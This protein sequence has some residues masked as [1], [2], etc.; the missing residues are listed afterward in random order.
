MKHDARV[1]RRYTTACDS[2][3]MEMGAGVFGVSGPG[4]KISLPECHFALLLEAPW[5]PRERLGMGEDLV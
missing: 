2:G 5:P 4:K 1:L 3:V